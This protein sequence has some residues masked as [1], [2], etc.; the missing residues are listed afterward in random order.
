MLEKNP[1][2][3]PLY[4]RLL[5]FSDRVSGL[6]FPMM[7]RVEQETVDY[8]GPAVLVALFSYLGVKVSQRKVVKSLR[9]ENKIKRYGLSVKDLA[10]GT[11]IAGS[12]KFVFWRK[13]NS[14]IS[15][16][17]LVVNKYKSPVGVEWQGIFHEF[18]DEDNGHYGVIT[19]IDKKTG[20]LRIFDPFHIFAGVD[21]KFEIK[22]F[23]KRWWDVNVVKGRTLKDSK[24]MFVIAPKD[25]SWPKELGMNKIL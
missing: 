13:K 19:R 12:G 2:L 9:A 24:V 7:K 6:A 11:R 17:N 1:H 15:D 20:F 18:S 21:R 4:R 10:R 23:T 16:V 5:A 14:K 22:E 3:R 25:A 8:C